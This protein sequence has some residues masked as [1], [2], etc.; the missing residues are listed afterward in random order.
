MAQAKFEYFYHAALSFY[1]LG[2]YGSVKNL[3]KNRGIRGK[4]G[5]ENLPNWEKDEE[6][7]LKIML[8]LGQIHFMNGD[9]TEAWDLYNEILQDFSESEHKEIM[10]VFRERYKEAERYASSWGLIDT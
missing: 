10:D 3:I 6:Y 7:Y 1:K 9:Y 8:L 5:F 4:I 2:K